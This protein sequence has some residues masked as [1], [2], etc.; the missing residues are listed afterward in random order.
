MVFA[1]ACR[2]EWPMTPTTKTVRM[3]RVT[4]AARSYS[5]P[6]FLA[7][8]LRLGRAEILSTNPLSGSGNLRPWKEDDIVFRKEVRPNA[9]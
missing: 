9:P 8:Q 2:A 5:V 3:W 7:V 4:C 6:C 1:V